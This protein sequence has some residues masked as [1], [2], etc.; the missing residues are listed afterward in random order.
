MILKTNFQLKTT[1]PEL[2]EYF[3]K[4]TGCDNVKEVKIIIDFKGSSKGY[5]H[6]LEHVLEPFFIY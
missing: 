5:T 3:N 2:K 1:E 6:N 4:L